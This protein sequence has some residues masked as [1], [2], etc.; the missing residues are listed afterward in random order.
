MGSKTSFPFLLK[1]IYTMKSANI[2]GKLDKEIK[3]YSI[4]RITDF[5]F[6]PCLYK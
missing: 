6:F 2:A 5:G 3:S 1:S 4:K